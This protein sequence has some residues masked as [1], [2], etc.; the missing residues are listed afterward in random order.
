M[1]KLLIIEVACNAKN[2]SIFIL[3]FF[4]F[5][6]FSFLSI[7]LDRLPKVFLGMFNHWLHWKCG[8]TIGLI[9]FNTLKVCI[10]NILEEVICYAYDPCNA[11]CFTLFTITSV[12]NIWKI[13]KIR[14]SET[15]CKTTQKADSTVQGSKDREIELLSR[16]VRK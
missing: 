11:M 15:R 12:H 9:S 14:N 6:S 16:K 2:L 5:L 10:T 13:T 1:F 7:F 8:T 4:F 3:V